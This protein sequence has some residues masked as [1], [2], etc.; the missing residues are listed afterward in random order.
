MNGLPMR[1]PIRLTT[2]SAVKTRVVG[3]LSPAT[4]ALSTLSI[5]STRSYMPNGI[6]VTRITPSNWKPPHTWPK[7]GVGNENPKLENAFP[8]PAGLKPTKLNPHKDDPQ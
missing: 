8:K 7:A 4:A 3:K 6:A 1:Q 2:P 5:A